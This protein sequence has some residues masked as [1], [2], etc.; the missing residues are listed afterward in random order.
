MEEDKRPVT[1][2][3]R[4]AV[5]QENRSLSELLIMYIFYIWKQSIL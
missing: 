1:S 3:L 2:T 4:L 5:A